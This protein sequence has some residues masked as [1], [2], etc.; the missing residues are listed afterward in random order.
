[1]PGVMPVGPG[2]RVTWLEFFFDLVYV[3]AFIRVTPT[4]SAVSVLSGG[5]L[6]YL[7]PLALWLPATAALA[8]LTCFLVVTLSIKHARIARRRQ[9]VRASE[10]QRQDAVGAAPPST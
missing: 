5:I 8:M 10:R 1:M 4:A 3:Y 6:S 2:A 9:R 7:L